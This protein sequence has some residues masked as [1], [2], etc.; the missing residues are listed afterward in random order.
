MITKHFDQVLEAVSIM[1]DFER[2]AVL[3]VVICAYHCIV[4]LPHSIR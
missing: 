1:S 2:V 4:Y 3:V